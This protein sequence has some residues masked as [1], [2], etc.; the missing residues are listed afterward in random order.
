MDCTKLQNVTFESGSCLVSIREWC[1]EKSGIRKI[2]IPKSV[3]SIGMEAFC[4][5]AQL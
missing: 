4:E 3:S 2:F 1:F 5:C